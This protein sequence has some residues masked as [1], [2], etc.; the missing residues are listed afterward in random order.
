MNALIFMEFPPGYTAYFYPAND[1]WSEI[2]P[3]A[4]EWLTQMYTREDLAKNR[5]ALEAECK[6]FSDTVNQILKENDEYA[7][8]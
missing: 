7:P 6:A 1:S 2:W 8:K 5:S 3:K 4:G